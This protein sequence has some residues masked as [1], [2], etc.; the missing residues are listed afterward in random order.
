MGGYNKHNAAKILVDAAAMGDRKAA[1]RHNV[2]DR[3]I[4]N[5]RDRLETDGELSVFFHELRDKVDRDWATARSRALR[6][7]ADRAAELLKTSK[8]LNAITTFIEKVGNLE[9]VTEALGVNGLQHHSAREH[10]PPDEGGKGDASDAGDD[11]AG[12]EGKG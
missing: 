2:T 3:T 4:K 12:D 6:I 1:R 5:Y 8:D 9:V 10:P 7:A 11:D